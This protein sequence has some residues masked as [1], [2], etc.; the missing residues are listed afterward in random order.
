MARC[1]GA[2]PVAGSDVQKVVGWHTTQCQVNRATASGALNGSEEEGRQPDWMKLRGR[3]LHWY[4]VMALTFARTSVFAFVVTI[5]V[6]AV[7]PFEDKVKQNEEA[8]EG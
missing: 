6:L 2:R 8:Q 5:V 7:R 3:K 1:S 4:D